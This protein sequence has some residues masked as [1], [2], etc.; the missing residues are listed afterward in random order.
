MRR[1][2]RRFIA[3]RFLDPIVRNSNMYKDLMNRHATVMRRM[4]NQKAAWECYQQNV[5]GMALSI[6]LLLDDY[7]QREAPSSE[8]VVFQGVG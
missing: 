7:E 2:I 8:G 3:K 5:N 6:N 4:D 1:L